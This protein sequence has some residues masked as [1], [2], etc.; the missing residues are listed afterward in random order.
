MKPKQ[1]HM[2]MDISRHRHS[3]CLLV[4]NCDIDLKMRNTFFFGLVKE[5]KKRKKFHARKSFVASV[6]M[7][8]AHATLI[9]SA[10]I[11]LSIFRHRRF[12]GNVHHSTTQL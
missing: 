3:S 4:V 6:E 10:I 12:D 8:E 9:R 1:A 5:K 2:Q 7:V 11:P